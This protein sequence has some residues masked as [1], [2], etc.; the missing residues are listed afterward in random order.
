MEKELRQFEILRALSESDSVSGQ[1]MSQKF[2]V[3]LRTIYRDVEDLLS[4]GVTIEGS[5][6][7]DGGYRWRGNN[8]C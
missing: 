6:G 4:N 7:I 8:R 3:S 2:G 1:I 5:K